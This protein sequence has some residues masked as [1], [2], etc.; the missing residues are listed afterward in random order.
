MNFLSLNAPF[1]R[2]VHF[3]LLR[4]ALKKNRSTRIVTEKRFLCSEK[5]AKICFTRVICGDSNHRKVPIQ[6]LMR[7][8]CMTSSRTLER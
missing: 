2:R 6:T 7:P 4:M 8:K 3:N 5:S 1:R